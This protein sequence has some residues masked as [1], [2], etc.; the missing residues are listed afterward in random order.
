M[1]HQSE[2]AGKILIIDDQPEL[3]AGLVAL[4]QDDGFEARVQPSPIGL[5][6]VLRSFDPDVVLMDLTIP[7]LSGDT[8]LRLDRKRMFPTSAP[9]VLYSGRGREE[10]ASLTVELSVDGFFSKGDDVNDLLR[11]IPKWVAVRRGRDAFTSG[12]GVDPSTPACADL[13]PLVVLR[14]DAPVSQ[15]SAMLQFG[16]YVVVKAGSNDL[17]CSL[18]ESCAAAALIVDVGMPELNQFVAEH[19]PSLTVPVLFLSGIAPR[20]AGASSYATM[21]RSA[22]RHSLI[23]AVDRV[24][25]DHGTSRGQALPS[26]VRARNAAATQQAYGVGR[27]THAAAH[28][29]P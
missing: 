19:M 14:T 5:P 26:G 25:A 27:V 10:L 8:V 12:R 15:P 23:S 4:L 3:A 20:I 9:I 7:T 17:A 11:R 21:P 13:Q 1:R 18:V 22:S 29:A 2:T 28:F 16:G 6:F 24:I